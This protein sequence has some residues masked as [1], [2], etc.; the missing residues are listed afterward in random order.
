MVIHHVNCKQVT[1]LLL[2]ASFY[3]TEKVYDKYNGHSFSS[4]NMDYYALNFWVF[5]MK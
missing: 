1:L 4:K 2:M 5:A 3:M